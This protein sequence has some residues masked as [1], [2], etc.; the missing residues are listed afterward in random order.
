M[1]TDGSYIY[2]ASRK[3]ECGFCKH[4]NERFCSTKTWD[5]FKGRY[6]DLCA[7]TNGLLRTLKDDVFQI[8]S[9]CVKGLSGQE[10]IQVRAVTLLSRLLAVLSVCRTGFGAV[11]IHVR[12]SNVGKDFSTNFSIALPVIVVPLKVHGR[13]LPQGVGRRSL[14]MENRTRSQATP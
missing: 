6:I 12:Y 10:L 2:D 1:D 14:N 4:F 9:I 11:E 3:L 5:Y 8:D 7:R 13:A